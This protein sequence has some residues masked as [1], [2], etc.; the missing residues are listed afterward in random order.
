MKT[1]G[2]LAGALV[3]MVCGMAGDALATV[4]VNVDTDSQTMHVYVNG[5]LRHE[6]RVSTGRRGYDTPS[7]SFRPQRMERQWYSRK[8]D[9]APMP[10]SIFFSGGY[11]IHGTNQVG[12]L[13]RRAS[14]GCI[15]LAPS[16]AAQLYNLVS[17]HRG[18]ARIDIDD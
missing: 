10:N 16:H 17:A 14:H 18:N 8:Y 4:R 12:R 6:W 2:A 13:G 1:A 5:K 15:R 11:A 3:V 7:G 9:D